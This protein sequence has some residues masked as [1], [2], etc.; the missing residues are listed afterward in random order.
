MSV[1]PLRGL[2]TLDAKKGYYFMNFLIGLY[3]DIDMKV[4]IQLNKYTLE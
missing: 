3:I 2:P 1:N 4:V